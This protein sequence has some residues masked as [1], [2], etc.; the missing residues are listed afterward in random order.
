MECGIEASKLRGLIVYGPV[1][2]HDQQYARWLEL[3]KGSHNPLHSDHPAIPGPVSRHCES[4]GIP[5]GQLRW[6]DDIVR[7]AIPYCGR[8]VTVVLPKHYKLDPVV[9][10]E[11]AQQRKRLVLVSLDH[12]ST[13]DIERAQSNLMVPGRTNESRPE[14]A[15]D[16]QA[17]VAEERERFA[18]R[19]PEKWKRFGLES[20]AGGASCRHI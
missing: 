1:F 10:Q 14:Y 11:A 3:T 16:A 13:R 17:A 8:Q 9:H 6:Q 2:N 15:A 20:R 4:V 19:M 5:L 7:M 18:H 12:F